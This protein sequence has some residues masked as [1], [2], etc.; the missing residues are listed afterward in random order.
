[1]TLEGF[2]A[3]SVETSTK[4]ATPAS[5]AHLAV[6]YV[7]PMLFL[8]ASPGVRSIRW[9]CLWAAAWNT[10]SGLYL[11]ITRA[12]STWSVTSPTWSTTNTSGKVVRISISKNIR[13]FSARSIRHNISGPKPAI[14]RTSSEPTEPAAP[15]INTRLPPMNFRIASVSRLAEGRPNKSVASNSLTRPIF[16]PFPATLGSLGSI[17]NGIPAWSQNWTNDNLWTWE[18]DGIAITA[19]STLWLWTTAEI[20]SHRPAMGTPKMDVPHLPGSSSTKATGT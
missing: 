17:L 13:G 16:T 9:T 18:A 19:M 8:T 7:P 12:I 2:T 15:V 5:W 3:L 1:M 10:T 14:W 6:T 20:S 11:A 4:V